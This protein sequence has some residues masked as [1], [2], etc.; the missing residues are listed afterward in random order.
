MQKISEKAVETVLKRYD[1]PVLFKQDRNLLETQYPEFF[2][3]L[4]R[5]DFEILTEAEVSTLLYLLQIV[6]FS[7]QEDLN[8]F[9]EFS[10]EKFDEIEEKLWG[11]YQDQHRTIKNAFDHYFNTIDQEELLAILEDTLTDDPDDEMAI[12]SVGKE[13]IMIVTVA[14]IMTYGASN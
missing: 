13:V 2:T 11:T 6:T 10:I 7:I 9:P 5:E 8:T 14:Q 3:I 4:L 12:T 1:D